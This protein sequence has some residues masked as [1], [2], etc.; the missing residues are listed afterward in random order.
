MVL[1]KHVCETINNK[2]TMFAFLKERI[3]YRD[4]KSDDEVWLEWH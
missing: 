3:E 2:Q 4:R 1:L